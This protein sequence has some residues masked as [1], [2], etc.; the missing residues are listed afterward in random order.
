MHP[1]C[2]CG[3]DIGGTLAKIVLVIEN[4]NDDALGDKDL[5]LKT[6]DERLRSLWGTEIVRDEERLKVEECH[7]V[8]GSVTTNLQDCSGE[9]PRQLILRFHYY[10]TEDI[11]ELIA[12]LNGNIVGLLSLFPFF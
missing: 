7:E 12:N 1:K 10:R 9:V 4:E 3:L 8:N 6:S 5:D 11:D 2:F